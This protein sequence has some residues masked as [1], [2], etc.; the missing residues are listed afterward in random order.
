M[1]QGFISGDRCQPCWRLWGLD[2]NHV[3]GLGGLAAHR[4][5]KAGIEEQLE[6]CVCFVVLS[7]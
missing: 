4:P 3:G 6:P 7:W 1:V 2:V 5:D